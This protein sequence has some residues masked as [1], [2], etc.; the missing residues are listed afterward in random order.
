MMPM[1]ALVADDSLEDK[2]NAAYLINLTGFVRWPSNAS[3]TVVCLSETSSIAPYVLAQSGRALAQERTLRA[4]TSWSDPSECHV[5]YWDTGVGPWGQDPSFSERY[6]GVLAISD[7]KGALEEGFAIQFY[8]RN[9]KLRFAINAENVALSDYQI[10]SKL[11]R[12]A[13]QVD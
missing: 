9:L 2:L 13:R 1:G 12:L 5:L 4:Q 8:M 3:E 7:Q 10:S 6:P 11:M